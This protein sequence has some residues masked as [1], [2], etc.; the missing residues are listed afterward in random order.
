MDI[1]N[2][3]TPSPI[4]E[5]AE[6][7]AARVLELSPETATSMGI[8]GRETEYGDYSPTGLDAYADLCRETLAALAELAPS[9]ENEAVT[10]DAMLERLGLD[11]ESHE[12]LD[13]HSSLNNIASPAQEIRAIFDLMPQESAEDFS[14]IAG[15]LAN[16]PAAID[17]Y[18]ASLRYAADRGAVSAR[19]QVAVVIEQSRAY[20]AED[21]F[22][23]ALAARGA[24]AHPELA[25]SLREGAQAA[26]AAYARLVEFL[27]GTLM[28]LAPHKDAV[29][30]E[31][32]ARGSRR[33]LGETVDLEETYAWGIEVL[34]D[35][36]AEQEALACE[37]KPGASIEEAKAILNADPSR[38]LHGTDAL[39]EWMQGISDTAVAELG[40]EQFDIP[41]PLRTLECC[42]A[43]TQDGG[44]Y[45][46]GPSSDFARPGRMWW[47]VPPGETEFTTWG[48]TS[49]VYHEGVPGHHLQVGTATYLKDTLNTW[50]RDLCWTSGYGEGWALYAERLMDELGYLSDPGDRMGMLD[51]QRMRAARVVFDIGVHLELEM[52]R[53]W[54]ERTGQRVWTPEIGKQFLDEHLEGSEGT[55]SFE[56]VRYL[57]WP[58]QA[59]SYKV[60]QRVW[61]ELRREAA[62]REG[63]SFDVKAFHSRALS[64]GSLPLST[65]VKAMRGELAVEA[66]GA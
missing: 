33:F 46:T 26:N 7:H 3:A 1:V 5:L 43:P 24:E 28:P 64:L 59:P 31:A 55:R 47:S 15:R 34:A 37:I 54:Q 9:T 6:A 21:G 4:D 19:R 53:E 66:P 49:T 13:P 58:G 18:T 32:Y 41:E 22:F 17:G 44:V 16:V 50:R 63:E 60:G 12:A 56:F 23:T 52:P 36:V 20:G 10:K 35:I 8:P 62:E 65:L 2:H 27:E 14:H 30:R 40:R 25:E 39:R 29:G 45:Y 11:I 48:E 61:D 51:A 57:G 38:V 42:I